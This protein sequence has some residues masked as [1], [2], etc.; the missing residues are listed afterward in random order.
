HEK[1][2]AGG[3]HR[4]ALL[5]RAQKQPVSERPLHR[6]SQSVV[7]L[8]APR[9]INDRRASAPAGLC[10]MRLDDRRR[11]RGWNFGHASAMHRETQF[12]RR[13]P[14]RLKDQIAIVTGAGRNIG[15]DISKLFVEEG[16][17]VAVVD[18][19]PGRGS[20]VANAI[21]QKN[22]GKAFWVV[23]DVPSPASVNIMVQPGVKKSG[24]FDIPGNNA[25]GPD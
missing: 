19:D 17:K 25:A 20:S 21:N 2:Q 18:L 6:K 4:A 9:S 10:V 14:M 16:A 12:N 22:P 1:S 3:H 11:L 15:E 23:C 5:R 8:P 7:S 13:I 24:S